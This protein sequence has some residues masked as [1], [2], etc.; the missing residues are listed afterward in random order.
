MRIHFFIMVLII[1]FSFKLSIAT[2]LDKKVNSVLSEGLYPVGKLITYKELNNLE[3]ISMSVISIESNDSRFKEISFI[4]KDGKIFDKVKGVPVKISDRQVFFYDRYNFYTFQLSN[5]KILKENKVEAD[6]FKRVYKNNLIV[7]DGKEIYIKEKK[8]IKGNNSSELTFVELDIPDY[9]SISVLN[10]HY[11][12]GN[13]L[14]IFKLRNST[15]FF[16]I[17]I[18]TGKIK[19]KL[20]F[21]FEEKVD[22]YACIDD[23]ILVNKQGLRFLT[24]DKTYEELTEYIFKAEK[25]VIKKIASIKN[26]S[27]NTK[28]KIYPQRE[29][30]YILIDSVDKTGK[31]IFFEIDGKQIPY[32]V[33]GENIRVFD[34]NGNLLKEISLEISGF[35]EKWLIESSIF[36]K[37]FEPIGIT[38]KCKSYKWCTVEGDCIYRYS[39]KE[40]TVKK[41]L[42]YQRYPENEFFK[43]IFY[44]D[45]TIDIS[46]TVIPNRYFVVVYPGEYCVRPSFQ[47]ECSK[48][49]KFDGFI[50]ILNDKKDVLFSKKL[51]KKDKVLR[52]IRSFPFGVFYISHKDRKL[53]M[54]TPEGNT[55]E[56]YKFDTQI[57]KISTTFPE[58]APYLILFNTGKKKI[59][60]NIF[61]KKFITFDNCDTYNTLAVCKGRN[62]TIR[63]I[64]DFY[65]GNE[66]FIK[67]RKI[68]SFPICVVDNYILFYK[69]IYSQRIS[70]VEKILIPVYSVRENRLVDTVVIDYKRNPRDFICYGKYL[71]EEIRGRKR[72]LYGLKSIEIYEIDASRKVKKKEN[73][74]VI[75]SY[76]KSEKYK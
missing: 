9:Y 69:E 25:P 55:E 71:I 45:Q 38:E 32:Y 61:L 12:E 58:K 48:Y 66:P 70:N 27:R 34:I 8:L 1:F 7:I 59:A 49:K 24:W 63:S 75:S 44:K 43:M 64:I 74:S 6:F 33:K 76:K 21:P 65:T 39:L 17:D 68:E 53:Y 57:D 50:Y 37:K 18:N 15:I 35:T 46:P 29:L 11:C 56:L 13:L 30:K 51:S 10:F 40:D 36:I 52:T 73:K 23:K 3:V 28:A 41:I 72:S 47:G 31:E 54:A 4:L 60:F 14:G 2:S 62:S 42:C 67:H 5:G 26:L 22:F 16:L 20:T 19:R